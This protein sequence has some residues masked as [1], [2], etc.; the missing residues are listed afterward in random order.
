[1]HGEYIK[2]IPGAKTAI[3]FIHGI[4][5]TPDHFRNL[6]PLQERIP[7]DWSVHNIL[8]HGHGGTAADFA[9]SSAEEWRKQIY[10]VF[11]NLANTHQR[12][13]IVGHSMGSLFAI[14]LAARYPK[15]VDKLFL[16]A[17]PMRPWLKPAMI[18][19]LFRLVFGKLDPTDSR[20]SALARAAGIQTTAKL[21]EYIPWVPRFLELFLEIYRTEQILMDVNATC[22]CYQS[23]NDELV[24]RC[25]EKVLLKNKQMHV[26]QLQDSSHFYY[27]PA[28]RECILD[29]F[30]KWFLINE[31]PILQKEAQL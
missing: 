27:S 1:M 11:V 9:A 30:Q 13:L 2:H 7:N 21:W 25:S 23:H 4:C 31:S 3:L 5:G 14:Q 18:V 19:D 29:D 17:V 10:E 15:K 20:K 26:Y 12:V 8:L 24:L 28:D 16:L 6:I 22:H